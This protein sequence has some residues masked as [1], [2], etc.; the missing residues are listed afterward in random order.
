MT[1]YAIID[2]GTNSIRYML[3][4]Y[5]DGNIITLHRAREN[6]RLG[7][8]LYDGKKQLGEE[9]MSHSVQAVFKFTTHAKENG[10]DKI[11]CVATS[12]VRDAE[13]GQFFAKLLKDASD[14]DLKILSGN[15][16]ALCGFTGAL[17]QYQ[18]NSDI[19]LV[20]IGGG[21]T[22]IIRSVSQ[23][24]IKGVSFDCGC[25]R[26][27]ELFGNDYLSAEIFVKKNITVPTCKK[28]VLIGGTA[29]TVAML[30]KKLA[31]Y[32]EEKLHMSVIPDEY[33][34]NLKNDIIKMHPEERE[35][36]CFFDPKRADILPFGLIIL[37]HIISVSDTD[38]VTVSEEG[39]MHGI[40]RLDINRFVW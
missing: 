13:N 25:V 36:L 8:G 34:Y 11:I 5:I 1:K 29:S 28:I 3:A 22:E 6:T 20:D 17:G 30:Y 33:I 15:T 27:S 31:E 7:K 14:T 2:I 9:Q 38:H 4:D 40:I 18:N 39:L 35:K 19:I 21:S 12:A 16:E 10:A 23:G 26:L 24:R 37:S 32:N